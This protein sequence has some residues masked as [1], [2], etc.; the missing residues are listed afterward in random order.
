MPIHFPHGIDE[1]QFR[2]P[3][4]LAQIEPH[5]PTAACKAIEQ[6]GI[7]DLLIGHSPVHLEPHRHG[8]QRDSDGEEGWVYQSMLSG[9]RMAVVAPWRQDENVTMR[10]RPAKDAAPVAEMKAGVV[11]TVESCDG[12][13]C[14][15]DAAGYDGYVAQTMLWGVY[16]GEKVDN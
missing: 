13:W 14:S 11:A 9:R 8:S 6:I 7:A 16:P 1:T 3:D 15:I 10:N 12:E 4:G 2:C 5:G